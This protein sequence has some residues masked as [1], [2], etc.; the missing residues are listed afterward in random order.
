MNDEVLM[1]VHAAPARRLFGAASLGVL[2]LMLVYLGFSLQGGLV[3]RV[4]LIVL[5]GFFLWATSK[6]WEASSLV[7][8]L[9]EE[10]LRES[11]GKVI[12]KVDDIDRVQRGTFAFKPSNGFMIILKDRRP[13]SWRPG[14]WWLIGRHLGIGGVTSAGQNKAMAEILTALLVKKADENA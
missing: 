4:F 1:S 6:L 8:E 13:R 10:E 5:G 11:T 9:T 14:V 2:G 12:V 7:L 3:G